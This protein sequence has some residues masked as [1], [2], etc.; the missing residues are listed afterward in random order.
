MPFSQI[1]V[2]EYARK[3]GKSERTLWRWI[4]EGCNPRDPK[5]L[6]EWQVRNHIR[7]T[8][9]ERARK[10]RRDIEQKAQ[11]AQPVEVPSSFDPP[12][13]GEDTAPPAGKRGAA[14]ALER[15]E[16][17]EERAHARLEAALARGDA[18][19]IQACQ[20]FWLKY[21]ETLRRLD[22]AVEVAR[23]QEETQ[24]PLRV[25]ADS[26]TFAAEWMRIAFMQFLSSES[27]GILGI[28]D[29]GELKVHAT[30]DSSAPSPSE[31][32]LRERK[33]STPRLR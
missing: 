4:K 23:R 29:I 30:G 17:A 32:T 12:G 2:N 24:I 19:Q 8:P 14:A 27:T 10:R 25:A 28:R 5:S 13:N 31:P 20:D 1:E 11:R 33:R 21:S 18:V 15:L 26:M 22:L 7:E 6:R 3:I 16:Q 9:I